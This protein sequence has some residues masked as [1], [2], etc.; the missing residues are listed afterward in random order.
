MCSQVWIYCDHEAPGRFVLCCVNEFV[1][2]SALLTAASRALR[3]GPSHHEEP[4]LRSSFQLPSKRTRDIQ[5][6]QVI[7][8]LR[9]LRLSAAQRP[10]PAP[11]CDHSTEEHELITAL[12]MTASLQHLHCCPPAHAPGCDVNLP[13][14]APLLGPG[15]TAALSWQPQRLP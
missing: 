8:F 12:N 4:S 13:A 7:H 9:P 11:G 3:H 2:G 15:A 5:L 1:W 6:L 14:Q 10:P